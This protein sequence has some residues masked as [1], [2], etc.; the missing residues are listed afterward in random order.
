MK[1]LVCL[2][3]FIFPVVVYCVAQTDSVSDKKVY[4]APWFVERFRAT[5]GTFVPINNTNIEVGL[6]NGDMGTDIDFENDLG[7]NR[8]TGTFIAGFQYRIKRRSRFDLNYYSFNRSSTYTLQKDIHF[9][10]DTFHI[11]S[12]VNA[13]FNTD[14]FRFSYGYSILEKPRYELGLIVGVHIV[15]TKA[16]L[17]ANGASASFAL[18]DDFGFTAPLPDV[19]I[20][21]GYAISNR[22]AINGEINYLSLTVGDITGRILGGSFAFSWHAL[23][24]LDLSLGYTG[25]NFKVDATKPILS[26]SFKWGYNGPSLTANYTFGKKYWVH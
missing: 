26:G 1:R 20:W 13:F 25:L 8:S 9:G 23:K 2:L 15:H 22:F 10:E 17:S 24:Q 7:F 4:R 12:S 14:I 19:G 5:A 3:L 16:G 11:N 6:T 21:G 18:E